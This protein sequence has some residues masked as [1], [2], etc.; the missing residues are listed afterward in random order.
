VNST[1]VWKIW[2]HCE[3]VVLPYTAAM[4][5]ETSAQEIVVLSPGLSPT[6]INGGIVPVIQD[7]RAPQTTTTMASDAP[8]LTR[9]VFGPSVPSQHCPL[10]ALAFCPWFLNPSAVSLLAT[11]MEAPAAVATLVSATA[12]VV[13]DDEDRTPDGEEDLDL[14]A[15]TTAS[16]NVL[17]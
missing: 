10:L 9:F 5:P 12:D 15:S 13:A 14:E 17:K 6:V 1:Q 2:P 16:F 3:S 11:S 8:F 4:P 7:P